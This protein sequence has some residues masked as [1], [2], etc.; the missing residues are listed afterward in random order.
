MSRSSNFGGDNGQTDRQTDYY[1]PAHACAQGNKSSCDIED[2]Y[3]DT[4][5]VNTKIQM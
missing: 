5:G 4:K 3:R 1:T 2:S